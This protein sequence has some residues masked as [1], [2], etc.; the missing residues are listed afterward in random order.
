[1]KSSSWVV[2]LC[3]TASRGQRASV[4]WFQ[5]RP[6]K[7]Q[8]LAL[9]PTRATHAF[10][11][12]GLSASTRPVSGALQSVLPRATTAFV[13]SMSRV[14]WFGEAAAVCT[15][16]TDPGPN[17]PET[18][19]S[20]P[21]LH[22]LPVNATWWPYA[23]TS[24]PWSDDDAL[25]RAL[26]DEFVVV[27]RHNRVVSH[28]R[29]PYDQ[30]MLFASFWS[31]VVAQGQDD[32][33]YC[34]SELREA[35]EAYDWPPLAHVRD[36]ARRWG[37]GGRTKTRL[38]ASAGNTSSRVHFDDHTGVFVQLRGT[39]E[40]ML[41]PPDDAWSVYGFEGGHYGLS[42]LPVDEFDV[43][44]WPRVAWS[45]PRVAR[46]AP[47]DVLL[48]PRHWWHHAATPPGANIMVT[49]EGAVCRPSTKRTASTVDM[50]Y[51]YDGALRSCRG[52]VAGA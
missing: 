52:R 20:E 40:V 29:E 4:V 11:R 44:E 18:D 16:V 28:D 32:T 10:E 21:R 14:P 2:A 46:L 22:E 1:M 9:F 49:I 24:V 15:D 6:L 42:A 12:V 13:P 45:R 38:W 36:A 5:G 39:R 26:S 50:W 30:G 43:A 48:V 17:P 51:A 34:I 41:W 23:Q 31:D 27:E 37:V 47:G 3:I 35:S 33:R 8:H 19:V 25:I 7:A